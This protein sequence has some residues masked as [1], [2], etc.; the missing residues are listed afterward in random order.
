MIYFRKSKLKFKL[1]FTL[2]LT[3]IIVKI[4]YE[5]FK[6]YFKETIR[7]TNI[8][9]KIKMFDFDFIFVIWTARKISSL[10]LGQAAGLVAIQFPDLQC[11]PSLAPPVWESRLGPLSHPR[12]PANHFLTPRDHTAKKEAKNGNWRVYIAWTTATRARYRCQALTCLGKFGLKS[13]GKCYFYMLKIQKSPYR[14]WE[15]P[16]GNPPP[17]LVRFTPSDD[18][19]LRRSRRRIQDSENLTPSWSLTLPLAS[20]NFMRVNFQQCCIT[21]WCKINGISKLQTKLLSFTWLM[22]LCF[23]C[24]S[25]AKSYIRKYIAIWVSQKW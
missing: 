14:S 18:G 22:L 2:S 21:N 5:Y 11:V 24:S 12:T 17:P 1:Q 15:G 13:A 3:L 8:N 6:L 25:L 4:E 9:W 23:S 16:G 19:A 7:K 20:P 10:S